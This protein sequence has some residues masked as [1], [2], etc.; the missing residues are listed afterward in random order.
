MKNFKKVVFA[1][2]ALLGLQSFAH[3]NQGNL[4]LLTSDENNYA[5][6]NTID[7][8]KKNQKQLMFSFLQMENMFLI[9]RR[10]K[11]GMSMCM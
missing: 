1:T 5:E 2:I 9:Q 11:M 8:F 4:Y 3:N 6:N 7:Y 10:M